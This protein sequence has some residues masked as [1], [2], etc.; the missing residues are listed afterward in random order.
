M[1]F[2]IS[3]TYTDLYQI[4]MGQAYFLDGSYKMPVSFD[5]YFRKIPFNNGY[6]VFAGLDDVL[7]I[8]E[9]LTF[10]PE[11]I[12]YLS[13]QGLNSDYLEILRHFRFRGSIFA[14]REGDLI[15]PSAPVLRVEGTMLEAQSVETLILNILNFQSLI[16]TKAARI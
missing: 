1:N 7:E 4:V 13:D 10:T 12:D 6:V 16:A 8:L 2:Q 15:F 9:S 11:D 14:M 3:G 5:Y